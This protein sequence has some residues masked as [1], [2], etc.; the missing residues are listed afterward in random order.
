MGKIFISQLTKIKFIIW[1]VTFLKNFYH[2]KILGRPSGFRATDDL[3]RAHLDEQ[4]LD[5]RLRSIVHH[6]AKYT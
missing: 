1:R 2:L 3:P 4:S 6:R 5:L